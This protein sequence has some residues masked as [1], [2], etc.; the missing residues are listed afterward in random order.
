MHE[1]LYIYVFINFIIRYLAIKYLKVNFIYKNFKLYIIKKLPILFLISL[2]LK[3]ICIFII[4]FKFDSL[5]TKLF[6]INC[7]LIARS[8]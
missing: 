5:V 3:N 4:H 8:L 7:L 6:P 2:S 1:F